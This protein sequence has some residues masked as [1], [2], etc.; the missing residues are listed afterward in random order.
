M[1]PLVQH[2]AE[3]FNE[4]LL[5]DLAVLGNLSF[6]EELFDL[7]LFVHTVG[8]LRWQKRE[9][10]V[11]F[12]HLGFELLL[13]D[14]FMIINVKSAEQTIDVIS[15]INTPALDLGQLSFALLSFSL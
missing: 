7:C 11:F 14:I 4:L 8:H 10:M 1:L 2:L 3:E 12:H 6:S 5:V 13:V 9:P 15:D